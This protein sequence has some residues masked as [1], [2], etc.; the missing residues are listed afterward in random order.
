MVIRWFRARGSLDLRI[1]ESVAAF[2]HL[3]LPAYGY[4]IAKELGV[5]GSRRLIAHGVLYRALD[6]AVDRG[7]LEAEWTTGADRAEHPPRRVYRITP[8]GSV[9]LAEGSFDS[10][11]EGSRT[12]VSPGI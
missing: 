7:L 4:A 3:N 10:V 11:P 2:N 12:W 9:V 6:R 1:L 5:D 8:S